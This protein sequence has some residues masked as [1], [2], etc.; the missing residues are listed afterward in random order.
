MDYTTL[1][2]TGLKVS[3][4]GLGGGGPSR[5]GQRADKSEAESIG[6]IRQAL[7]AGINF[8]DT[9]EGYGTEE[10]IGKGIRGLDRDAVVIS[11]K[12]SCRKGISPQTVQ[13]SLEASLQRLGTDCV[14]VYSL[15][16]VRVEDYDRLYAEIVPTLVR[17]REQGMLRFIGITEAFNSDPTH[18]ALQR[19]VQDDVWD[20]MMVGFNILNQSAR[21]TVLAKATEKNIGIQVMFAVRVALS[22]PARLREVIAD[23]IKK[24]QLDP[25]DIDLND[26]LGFL[27]KDQDAASLPDAAYRFCRDEPGT[28][29]ILSGTGDPRHLQEN[30]VSF[31]RLPL[32]ATVTHRLMHIFRNADAVSGQ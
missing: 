10:I 26:P 22:N 15:H 21:E 2:R 13:E 32:P 24:K 29:V 28:H 11:T 27:V 30:I 14:D 31:S 23:L 4:I 9:A 1:G 18:Q 12:K 8:F 5:L 19:A 17:M 20:V 6:I 3:V 7:D 25:A 16:G